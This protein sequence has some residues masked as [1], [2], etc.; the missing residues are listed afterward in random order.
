MSV[1]NL[2]SEFFV[3]QAEISLSGGPLANVSDA[4][5]NSTATTGSTTE[6]QSSVSAELTEPESG[7]C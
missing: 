3:F 6:P 7:V 4:L 5:L 2:Y 1:I